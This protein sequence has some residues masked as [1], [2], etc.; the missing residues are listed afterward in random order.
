MVKAC[1]E[2]IVDLPVERA[3]E[4]LS[5]FTHINRIHPQV[6]TVDQVTP[7]QDRGLGA[8][9]QCN[10]YDGHMAVEKITEWDQSNRFYKIE[11]ID[12]DFPVKAALAILKAEDAGNGQTK[13]TSTME[14]KAKYGIFGK[15]MEHFILKPQLGA[16][17]DSVF[18]G[19][20]EFDKTGKEIEKGFKPKTR[21]LITAC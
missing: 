20:E 2:R 7:D 5:D 19:I 17:I 9:R 4:I 13:L 6:A 11:I 12:S 16:A 18:A 10:M 21:S 1:I 15:L 14:V 8:I 3:W